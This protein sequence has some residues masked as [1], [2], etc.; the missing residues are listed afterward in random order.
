MQF[1]DPL[2]T[3]T[4][5]RALPGAVSPALGVEHARADTA[6]SSVRRGTYSSQEA[7]L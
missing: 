7:T 6:D 5:R 2:G 4:L 1:V 3:A